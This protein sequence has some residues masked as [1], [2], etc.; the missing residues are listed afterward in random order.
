[1]ARL[2]RFWWVAAAALMFLFIMQ[3]SNTIPALD[4]EV[5][6]SWNDMEAQYKQRNDLIPDLLTA[7]RL[8]AAYEKGALSEVAQARDE[9][10]QT[11]LTN[12]M[13]TDTEAVKNFQQ[14]QAGLGASLERLMGLA[15]K[16]PAL[17][18]DQSFLGAQAQIVAN[19]QR[20]AMARRIYVSVFQ[21]YNLHLRTF[22]GFIWAMIYHSKPKA[23]FRGK[24]DTDKPPEINY[25][26]AQ[27]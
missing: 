20:I 25:G 14:V 5:A 16:Y 13:L 1:M 9:A 19:A 24:D 21:D 10:M 6:V 11:S 17:K 7:V 4:K 3:A 26:G 22:P 15:D 23:E 2:M 18:A 27:E 12:D 8:H